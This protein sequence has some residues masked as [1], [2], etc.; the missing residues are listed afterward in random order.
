MLFDPPLQHRPA[1]CLVHTIGEGAQLV[2]PH[3]NFLIGL[4]DEF[5]GIANARLSR[6]LI[7]HQRLVLIDFGLIE[8]REAVVPFLSKVGCM[9]VEPAVRTADG[10]AIVFTG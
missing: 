3:L 1:V 4:P 2:S 7:E 10:K 5:G 6:L 8:Y 9:V